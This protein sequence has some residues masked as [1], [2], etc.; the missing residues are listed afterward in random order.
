MADA[1]L[2]ETFLCDLLR[3]ESSD[4]EGPPPNELKFDVYKRYVPY[5]VAGDPDS[6]PPL[7]CAEL[8][9][10]RELS[11]ALVQS[12]HSLWGEYVYNAARWMA[13][14]ID[15]RSLA[16]RGRHVCELGAGA[17]LPSIVAALNGAKTVVISDYGTDADVGLLRAIEHNIAYAQPHSSA[18]MHALSYIWG[19]PVDR[20]VDVL[21]EYGSLKFDFVLVAD[22]IFN[23]SEHRRLLSS[24]KG[25]LRE[26]SGE[27]AVTFSHHDPH[28]RE[29]DLNFFALA[30]E[31]FGFDVE[32]V[33][34]QERLAYP[35]LLGDNWDSERGF[36]YFYRLRLPV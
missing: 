18:S 4:E 8:W 31:E 24:I 36:V 16:V 17:G 29:L 3:T 27:C 2:E 23:R 30:R 15:D 32:C 14:L 28:K 22:C 11:L 34:Q 35:F 25:L 33:A 7:P 21:A 19:Q 10:P 12:H 20:F 1:D 5:D 26:G 9:G 13:D 6:L